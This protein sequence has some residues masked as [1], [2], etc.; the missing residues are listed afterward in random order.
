MRGWVCAGCVGLLCGAVVLV[1]QGER[2][3]S[4]SGRVVNWM[5]HPAI[6]YHSATTAD[7]VAHL[8]QRMQSGEVRLHDDGPSGYLRSVLDELQIS[9]DS[10]M[11]VFARD[12]VQGNL[13]SPANPRALFFNDTT[14]VGWVR[15]GFIELA[16]QDPQEGVIF[17]SLNNRVF[18][19]P[20]ITRRNDCLTC[21]YSFASVG[22]PGMLDKSYLQFNVTHRVPFDKRWGGWYVTG[23]ARGGHLGNVTDLAHGFDTPPPGGTLN[24]ST[25]EGKFDTTGYL[26]PQSD[27][28]ALLVFEH[29]MQMM[30]LLTR[31]GWEARVLE[32]RQGKTAD[33]LRGAGDDPSEP[34]TPLEDA[35]QEVVDYML[36][37]EEAPLPGPIQGAT[38]FATR[39]TSMGPRDHR[40]RSLRQLDLQ[41]RLL[42][43]P[44][45]YMIYS[46]QFEQLPPSAKRAIYRRMWEVLSG[47][48]HGPAYARLTPETRAAIVEILRDTK[49]D[50]PAY[51]QPLRRTSGSSRAL[52]PP[53]PGPGDGR[54]PPPRSGSSRPCART[55]HPGA[56]RLRTR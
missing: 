11:L 53:P 27:L 55:A 15:G 44:C 36:F 39:F 48:E 34:P 23:R 47:Q 51:F 37:V 45:S 1:A 16:S 52:S 22:V 29:Q 12:S 14:V 25:L 43:Y 19:T 4:L 8:I 35:A 5:D 46:T 17:Y 3:R 7:P 33:Q 30:N 24:W 13:I 41:T 31:I 10:Q 50:L 21:H 6:R 56:P 32:F 9:V 18:G 38:G 49:P 40:G 26:A 28:V 42:T 2:N 54:L 20:A